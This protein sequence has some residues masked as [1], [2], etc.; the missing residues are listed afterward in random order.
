MSYLDLSFNKI[1][2]ISYLKKLDAL[3]E[4]NIKN[5]KINCFR[6]FVNHS[7]SSLTQLKINENK[8]ECQDEN[9]QEIDYDNLPCLNKVFFDLNQSYLFKNFINRK[10][11]IEKYKFVIFKESIFFI[12]TNYLNYLD[13][14]LAL[15]YL[16]NGIYFNLFYDF[17][18]NN[19]LSMCKKYID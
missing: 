2:D 1:E 19:F 4:L 16:K 9:K 12:V 5:N 18:I 6:L 3:S 13:C 15:G 14:D 8:N 7:F 17:Q 10:K 11:S